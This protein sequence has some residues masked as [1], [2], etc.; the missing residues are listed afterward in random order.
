MIGQRLACH[1]S[2]RRLCARL[3]TVIST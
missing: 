1:S 2:L 3:L